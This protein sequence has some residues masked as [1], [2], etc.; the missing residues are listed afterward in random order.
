MKK[1]RFW[2]IMIFAVV[3]YLAFSLFGTSISE[4]TSGQTSEALKV[5]VEVLKSITEGVAI[6]IAGI[7]AY[8]VYIKNRYD[9]P[10][11][12]IQQ[13]IKFYKLG[14][15]FNYLSVFIIV[16]NE[17]KTKL[18]LSNGVIY[19]RKVLPLSPA[20][21]NLIS[22]SNIRDVRE[23]Q[24]SQTEKMQTDDIENKLFIDYGQRVGWKTLGKRSWKEKFHKFESGQTREIQFDFLFNDEV[25]VIEIISYFKP[26]NADHWEYATL[27]TIIKQDEEL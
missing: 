11:P 15:K 21:K 5:R 27:H 24:N 4:L 14:N 26:K 17:G 13:H 8:E 18:D 6:I 2:A 19:V 23:G 22:E 9:Y 20:I 16:T 1:I 7:W 10:Y 12:K 25:D 3:I